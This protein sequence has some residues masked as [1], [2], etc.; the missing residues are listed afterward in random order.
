VEGSTGPAGEFYVPRRARLGP[1]ERWLLDSGAQ[2]SCGKDGWKSRLR[3]PRQA[4][5]KHLTGVGGNKV[6]LQATGARHLVFGDPTK[7]PWRR[8]EVMDWP[9]S[10]PIKANMIKP[11]KAAP[12]VLVLA[13]GPAH[14]VTTRE[15]PANTTPRRLC[16]HKPLSKTTQLVERLNLTGAAALRNIHKLANGVKATHKPTKRYE[17]QASEDQARQRAA[18]KPRSHYPTKRGQGS[19]GPSTSCLA[20]LPTWTASPPAN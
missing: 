20:S 19:A 13:G 3:N 6:S 1:A 15:Q 12:N 16:R 14:R 18:P 10:L 7:L 4:M 5:G 2:A 11:R 17:W 9:L 8:M